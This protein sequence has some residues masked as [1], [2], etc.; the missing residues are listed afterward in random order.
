MFQ[1]D[2]EIGAARII[3][4]IPKSKQYLTR[5]RGDNSICDGSMDKHFDRIFSGS[6]NPDDD[7]K[8]K[9]AFESGI[10]CLGQDRKG[11]I[12]QRGPMK[13]QLAS[14]VLH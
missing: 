6:S 3:T 8:I 7:V 11:L 10:V 1:R 9:V 5:R 12:N 13:E 14:A 4:D 2:G